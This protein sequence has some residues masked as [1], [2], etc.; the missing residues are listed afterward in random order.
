MSNPLLEAALKYYDMGFSVIPITAGQ[1]DPPYF[2][3]KPYQTTRATKEQIT[4]WWTKWPKANIAIV[5]GKLSNLFIADLDKYKEEYKEELALDFFPDS[6]ITATSLS[7]QKGEHLY[8]SFP[9]NFKLSGRSDQ[10]LAIDFRA[11]GNYIIAPPSIN[12]TGTAYQWT[13]SIFDTPLAKV[14]DSYLAYIINNT[15]YG[16]VTQKDEVVTSCDINL[17]EGSRNQSLFHVA[18]LLTR[19]G[20][21][22]QEVSFVLNLLAKQCNPPFSGNEIVTTCN[23][24]MERA[25]RKERNIMK[26]VEE[27]IAVTNGYFSVTDCYMLLQVV[28]KEEKASVRQALSRLKDKVIEKHGIKD[29]VYKRIEKDFKFII[30]DENEPDEVEYPVELPLGLNDIAEVSQGNIILVAGEFNAGKTSFLLNILKDNKNKLPIRYISSEMRKSEFKKRFAPF[31]KPLSF[32]KQDNMTEYIM[33]SFDFHACIKP[34]ALNIID[35]MEFRES[36]YTKGA[37]YLTQIHDKLT[38]GIAV[39]AVQKKEGLRMPRSG[40][41]IVEKPRL[42]ISFSKYNSSGE[43]PQGI[44]EILKCKMPKRGKID[45]K[46]LRFEITNQGSRFR[47][48]NDWGYLK[49]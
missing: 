1:K 15:I 20:A 14:P 34:D 4:S 6:L 31:L 8:F 48:L 46:K 13:N 33:K 47:V 35:Y 19:G 49:F 9:D 29:G 40:D 21:K 3:W 17:E 26:E 43:D 32:W 25:A 16:N 18:N 41:M 23:S 38:T 2:S 5:T 27:Y 37:E 45:G 12:G 11:E 7:P 22:K 10:K 24:A 42:A 30:F 44:C 36:D 28:T 39:V